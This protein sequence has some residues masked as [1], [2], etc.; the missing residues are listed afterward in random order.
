M[1]A[2]DKGHYMGLKQDRQTGQSCH[3]LPPWKLC[4]GEPSAIE[5]KG[6]KVPGNGMCKAQR[7]T[8]LFQ[9]LL[10]HKSVEQASAS[11]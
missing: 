9:P 3:R 6:A 1:M 5:L 7:L 10:I 11:E 2:D 8:S 4:R